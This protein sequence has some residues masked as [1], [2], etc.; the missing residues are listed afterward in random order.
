MALE[1]KP[2]PILKGEDAERFLDLVKKK[3]SKKVSPERKTE[4]QVLVKN[5]LSKSNS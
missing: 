1:I 3:E 4:M 5:V 2:T